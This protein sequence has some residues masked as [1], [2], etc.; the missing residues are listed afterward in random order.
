MTSSLISVQAHVAAAASRR[1][2]RGATMTEYAM[3][4][5]CVA[6]V[7]IFGVKTLG[8]AVN[9]AFSGFAGAI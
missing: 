3:L 5:A 2:E 4:L 1:G 7:A 8:T 6:M 9:S